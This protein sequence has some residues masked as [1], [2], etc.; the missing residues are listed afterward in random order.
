[1]SSLAVI[2]K[3]DESTCIGCTKCIE[4][5]PVDAIIGAAK[6]MHTVIAD[7]CI[8]CKLCLPPCPVSCIALVPLQEF[9]ETMQ[10][11]RANLGKQHARAR[12][13]RL[14]TENAIKGVFDKQRTSDDIKAMIAAS[15]ERNQQKKLMQKEPSFE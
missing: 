2:A 12:K 8:G 13:E 11:D 4:A 10:R 1:M 15:I 14:S 5:C 3:I 6:H 7:Y 9:S